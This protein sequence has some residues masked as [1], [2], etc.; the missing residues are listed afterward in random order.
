MSSVDSM[1]AATAYT[2]NLKVVTRNER[3]FEAGN[4][5]IINPWN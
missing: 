1:L 3:D 2:H 4:V 5:H